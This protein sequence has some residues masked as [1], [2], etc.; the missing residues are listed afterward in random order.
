MKKKYYAF[1]K[2][3]SRIVVRYCAIALVV[4]LACASLLPTLLNY[5]PGS[6][7]TAFD[8]K[9]SYISYIQQFCIIGLV[10]LFLI[11]VLILPKNLKSIIMTYS[12]ITKSKKKVLKI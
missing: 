2:P 9:M 1:K 11:F 3:S 12:K 8:I 10:I 7:N 4:L 6:I 5:A